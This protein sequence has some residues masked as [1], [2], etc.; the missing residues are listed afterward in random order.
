[1]NDLRIKVI[2]THRIQLLL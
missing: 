1:M 2:F